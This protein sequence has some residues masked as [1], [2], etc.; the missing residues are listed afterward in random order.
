MPNL[1]L[2]F[3]FASARGGL[4]LELDENLGQVAATKFFASRLRALCVLLVT[5]FTF[6]RSQVCLRYPRDARVPEL[7]WTGYQGAKEST[8][9]R[10]ER[11]IKDYRVANKGLTGLRATKSEEE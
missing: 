3:R 8:K 11:R 1:Q 9:R 10:G 4:P 2:R 6:L 5:G 7:L